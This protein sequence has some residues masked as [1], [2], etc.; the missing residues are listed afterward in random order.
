MARATGWSRA[1]VAARLEELLHQRALRLAVDLA[2]APFG[3]HATACLWLT[4]VPGRL[5]ATGDA[6]SS[7]PE[8]TFA[9][10]VTGSASLPVTVTCRSM[11]DLYAYVTGNVGSLPAVTQ[12]DVVPVLHRLKQAGTRV[13]HGRLATG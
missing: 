5:K 2:Y 10:A 4:V 7:H 1:R 9:A 3:F 11:D 8:T 13:H 12:V 6:L